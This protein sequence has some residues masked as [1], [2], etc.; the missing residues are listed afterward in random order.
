M[1]DRK[2]VVAFSAFAKKIFFCF[3]F[4]GSMATASPIK[5][6]VT[7]SVLADMVNTVA[8]AEA[9]VKSLVAADSDVHVFEPSPRDVQTIASA[10]LVVLNGLGLDG[11]MDRL[12]RAANH[13]GHRIVASAGA[14]LLKNDPHCWQDP[15]CGIAYVENIKRGLVELRPDRKQEI[16]LRAAEYI[17]Q[18]RAILEKY[19]TLFAAI[20]ANERK[21]L[22]SHDSLGYFGRAYEIEIFTLRGPTTASEGS[23]GD[24]AN[25]AKLIRDKKL[26][27]AFFENIGDDR[28]L[29]QLAK[30]S[31]LRLGGTLYTDS[32]SKQAEGAT[33]LKMIE[34]NASRVLQQLQ[35]AHR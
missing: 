21:I 33:Y 5:T 31:G 9:T 18:I 12:L 34:T 2:Q 20:P 13:K 15:L 7:F 30:D 29:R 10:D 28:A 4:V 14:T 11:W 8:G 26:K 35:G 1:N 19:R 25:T 27:V 22:T 23:A 24:L 17:L 3:W 32:L 6:N 16:E